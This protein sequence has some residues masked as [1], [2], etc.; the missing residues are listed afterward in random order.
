M[1]TKSIS[2]FLSSGFKTPSVG[3]VFNNEP[4]NFYIETQ[5]LLALVLPLL[6]QHWQLPKG[7]MCEQ[8]LV[9]Y[10][11]A[12]APQKVSRTKTAH[13]LAVF[14]VWNFLHKP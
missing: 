1:K 9:S 3:F 6:L 12:F 5:N 2:G 11:L 10:G 13:W 4:Q 7:L 8:L 14:C